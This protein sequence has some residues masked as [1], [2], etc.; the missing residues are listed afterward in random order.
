M[1]ELRGHEPTGDLD[2]PPRRRGAEQVAGLD[3]EAELLA[4]LEAAVLRRHQ[5]DFHAVGQELLD[6]DPVP[7]DRR[8]GAGEAQ[9]DPVAARQRVAGQVHGHLRRAPLGKGGREG[10]VVAAIGPREAELHGEGLRHREVRA[11]DDGAEH[12]LAARAVDAAV[13][14]EEGLVALAE[15]GAPA[16]VEIGGVEGRLLDD[17]EARVVALRGRD[18]VRCAVPRRI[19]VREVSHSLLVRRARE[20]LLVATGEH[21]DLGAGH[22]RRGGQGA[23]PDQEARLRL[24]DRQP[25]VSDHDDLLVLGPRVLRVAS[26]GEEE[27]VGVVAEELAEIDVLDAQRVARAVHG[28]R[29]LQDGVAETLAVAGAVPA[30]PRLRQVPQVMHHVVRVDPLQRQVG[31][32]DIHALERQEQTASGRKVNAA[33]LEPQ[34]RV[35]VGHG[36]RAHRLL[37]EER[38]LGAR[39]PLQERQPIALAGQEGPAK[40]EAAV[41]RRGRELDLRL[42]PDELPRR[43]GIDPLRAT[44]LDMHV[45]R[46]LSGGREMADPQARLDLEPHRAVIRQ[47]QRP[48]HALEPLREVRR[49]PLAPI[50]LSREPNLLGRH[51]TADVVAQRLPIP[52]AQLQVAPHILRAHLV[53]ERQREHHLAVPRS[54]GL[55]RVH[56]IQPRRLE[57]EHAVPPQRVS[58]Q[59]REPP[60]DGDRVGRRQPQLLRR[61][62][63][64][65][66][67]ILPHRTP[68]D[69]REHLQQPIGHL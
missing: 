29:L 44:H 41:A 26:G 19:D 5:L 57:A 2:P 46:R 56:Q 10:L 47:A 9:L 66:P 69:R 27:A 7:P 43:P 54:P 45:F 4:G 33:G 1:A 15:V 67:C 61:L 36:H 20:N 40:L 63:R 37:L 16:R 51:A 53:V 49:N 8:L 50:R 35:A 34:Q 23:D 48:A 13:G 58:Q 11:A 22:W 62:E 6:L 25:Q 17:H 68:G 12:G 38:A 64:Q 60:R 59:A 52:G 24:L 39:Q 65:R 18:G 31:L 21:G 32:R 30:V 28:Q 14:I 3:Q 55:P 42:N